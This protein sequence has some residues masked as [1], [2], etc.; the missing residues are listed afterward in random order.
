MTHERLNM[1]MV[2]PLLFHGF[3]RG[4]GAGTERA[5]CSANPN[6]FRQFRNLYISHRFR[7]QSAFRMAKSSF[8][9]SGGYA[10]VCTLQGKA[11]REG[12]LASAGTSGLTSIEPLPRTTSPN[13]GSCHPACTPRW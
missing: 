4:L 7:R 2:R 1:R 9:W 6:V 5:R 3:E 12:A 8:K 13:L 10:D 11:G